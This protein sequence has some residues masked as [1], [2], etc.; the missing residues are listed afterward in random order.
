MIIIWDLIK[1]TQILTLQEPNVVAID[2][3]ADGKVLILGKKEGSIVFLEK[4]KDKDPYNRKEIKVDF[5]IF[6][7]N[8]S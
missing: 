6:Y 3:S 7:T 4:T 2:A 5:L 1:L 8:L